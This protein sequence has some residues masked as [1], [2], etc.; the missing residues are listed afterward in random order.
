[1]PLFCCYKIPGSTLGNLLI[2]TCYGG[3]YMPSS[4]KIVNNQVIANRINEYKAKQIDEQY[5]DKDKWIKD[6]YMRDWETHALLESNIPYL[7]PIE[8]IPKFHRNGLIP[9]KN[10]IVK[11]TSP[12]LL[13]IAP[14]LWEKRAKARA[15]NNGGIPEYLTPEYK[16]A[17][18]ANFIG[19]KT[20]YNKEIAPLRV[21]QTHAKVASGNSTL[22]I[23]HKIAK[24]QDVVVDPDFARK[25]M[26]GISR[27]DF[28]VGLEEGKYSTASPF[29]HQPVDRIN[30]LQTNYSLLQGIQNVEAKNGA[31]MVY[32]L[33][34]TGPQT[35]YGDGIV[36]PNIITEF[37]ATRVNLFDKKE[38]YNEKYLLKNKTYNAV[39]GFN[40]KE[41]DYAMGLLEK[42]N[43]NSKSLTKEEKVTLER[44]ALTGYKDTKFE[45]GADGVYRFTNF[46][47][48][49]ALNG[50]I[51][52]DDV[53]RGIEFQ[54]RV[55]QENGLWAKGKEREKYMVDFMGHKMFAHEAVIAEA[56]HQVHSEDLTVLGHNIHMAD[57][58]W[59][60]YFFNN[61]KTSEGFSSYAKGLYGGSFSPKHTLD[62]LAFFHGNTPDSEAILKKLIR[63]SFGRRANGKTE[64]LSGKV[65]DELYKNFGDWK[66]K[67]G[68]TGSFTQEALM[69]IFT[70]D[71]NKSLFKQMTGF[72]DEY[73]SSLGQGT[74]HLASADAI[75]N[76]KLQAFLFNT[77]K[78]R[79]D[80]PATRSVRKLVGDGSQVFFSTQSFKSLE[81]N[82]L[83]AAV[84][85]SLTGE[86]RLSNGFTFTNTGIR[87]EGFGQIGPSRNAGYRVTGLGMLD[88]NSKI[89]QTF[90]QLNPN[91]DLGGYSY[92]QITPLSR[93]GLTAKA[94]ST[95]TLFGQHDKLMQQ[96]NSMFRYAGVYDTAT[97]TVDMSSLSKSERHALRLGMTNKKGK[98]Y[99]RDMTS[100]DI[101]EM[102]DFTFNSET[103][104]RKYREHSLKTDMGV[105]KLI[106]A[107]DNYANEQMKLNPKGHVDAYRQEYRNL[108]LDNTQLIYN[109]RL[110]GIKITEA[111]LA[112][113]NLF[114][115][116]GYQDYFTDIAEEKGDWNL[117]RE[118]V[119]KLPALESYYR[120]HRNV[121]ERTV[122]YTLSSYGK[123]YKDGITGDLKKEASMKY[124]D[125]MLALDA[126][127]DE[128]AYQIAFGNT[129]EA[130][131]VEARKILGHVNRPVLASG[132][133]GKFQID[134]TGFLGLKEN[135][136]RRNGN[137]LTL[138]LNYSG[139][140]YADKI[141][142]ITGNEKKSDQAK[143][144]ILKNF[145]DWL[146]EKGIG[147]KSDDTS[148]LSL[149]SAQIQ[150]ALRKAKGSNPM[151]GIITP[152]DSMDMFLEQGFDLISDEEIDL[153]NRTHGNGTIK[154][155]TE[156][157]DPK[158]T[159]E[160]N[161]EGFLNGVADDI[162]DILA[163]DQEAANAV[164]GDIAT[165]YRIKKDDARKLA[166]EFSKHFFGNGGMMRIDKDSG[167]IYIGSDK[168]SMVELGI[169]KERFEDGFFFNE[170][171]LTGSRHASP[172]GLFV[173]GEGEN[174]EIA[175]KSIYGAAFDNI[176]NRFSSILQG[177]A[178]EGRITDGA[179]YLFGVVRSEFTN[180]TAELKGDAHDL[181]MN[182]VFTFDDLPKYL[183]RMSKNKKFR[184]EILEEGSEFSQHF[185]KLI[186]S[187]ELDGKKFS[188]LLTD[189][190]NIID[191]Y[192]NTI[193]DN[194]EISENAADFN[195]I[196]KQLSFAYKKANKGYATIGSEN[197]TAFM[198]Q[199]SRK[200]GAEE[201]TSS[202]ATFDAEK[203]KNYIEELNREGLSVG[204]NIVTEFEY[205]ALKDGKYANKVNMN[206]IAI[207]TEDYRKAI[208]NAIEN[209]MVD[210][211]VASMLT[212]VTLTDGASAMS[213]MAAR[214][215]LD[216]RTYQQEVKL[217][218]LSTAN[219]DVARMVTKGVAPKTVI[220]P[221][222]KIEFVYSNGV[223]KHITD[224]D[225]FI[226]G[227][228]DL[229]TSF[230]IKEDSIMQLRYF[231]NNRELDAGSISD[232]LNGNSSYVERI[233][234]ASNSNEEALR[235]LMENNIEGRFLFRS[236]DMTH[237]IK[238][239]VN[240]EKTESRVI[241]Y[242]LG[243]GT[244]DESKGIRK[245]LESLGVYKEMKGR[246]LAT[247]IYDALGEED[248]SLFTMAINGYGKEGKTEEQVLSAIKDAGFKNTADFRKAI[249]KEEQ[250]PWLE[251]ENIFKNLGI[252]GEGENFDLVSN[253]TNAEAKHGEISVFE[254]AYNLISQVEGQKLN[255]QV[256][257]QKKAVEILSKEAIPG[258]K[259]ENKNGK[260][261]VFEDPSKG[262]YNLTALRKILL[263]RVGGKDEE[264]NT[265]LPKE[266]YKNWA[267]KFNETLG[268]TT[269]KENVTVQSLVN[270]DIDAFKDFRFDQRDIDNMLLQGFDE[271]IDKRVKETLM[272][273]V[274][275]LYGTD[276]ANSFYNNSVGQMSKESHTLYGNYLKSL[277]GQ[278]AF[279]RQGEA[280][281][282][283][284]YVGE[285]VV[286]NLHDKA[287]AKSETLQAILDYTNAKINKDKEARDKAKKA[288][289]LLS[290][291]QKE[292]INNLLDKG[293]SGQDI[294]STIKGLIE[295]RGATRISEGKILEHYS[296][297]MAAI[298]RE[299]N[300]GSGKYTLDNLGDQFTAISIEDVVTDSDSH[301]SPFSIFNK[302]L[303]IDFRKVGINGI[304]NSTN[305]VL[306]LPFSP[307]GATDARGDLNK[308]EIQ[309]K[310]AS[311]K[312]M[313]ESYKRDNPIGENATKRQNTIAKSIIELQDQIS[314]YTSSNSGIMKKAANIEQEGFATKANAFHFT[315]DENDKNFAKLKW[316]NGFNLSELAAQSNRNIED[317]F[318]RV[319][320][321]AIK[322]GIGKIEGNIT[323][324][325]ENAAKKELKAFF[326]RN[327]DFKTKAIS[328]SFS[329]HSEE[330][331]EK[332]YNQKIKEIFGKDNELANEFQNLLFD[333]LREN[334]TIG[335]NK[336]Y[337]I[338]YQGS[339]SANRIY[340]S[341]AVK[342]NEALVNVDYWN[343]K[344]GDFDSDALYDFMAKTR[345]TITVNG[346]TI[347]KDI[348]YGMYRALQKASK[349]NKNISVDIGKEGE[350]FFK[351][352]ENA[353]V[354]NAVM[355]G[356]ANFNN[357]E[358]NNNF[359]DAG[360]KYVSANLNGEGMSMEAALMEA[361][362]DAGIQG[363][364]YEKAIKKLS[365]ART[366][367]GEHIAQFRTYTAEDSKKYEKLFEGLREEAETSYK[368]HEERP[369]KI[370]ESLKSG[371]QKKYMAKLA[372]GKDNSG[373]LMAALEYKANQEAEQLAMS[374]SVNKGAAGILDVATND[375]LRMAVHAT[376]S[377]GTAVFNQTELEAL[378]GF[379]MS[380]EESA[381]IS[382]SGGVASPYSVKTVQDAM[383][384]IYEPIYNPT[385][386]KF[387]AAKDAA[388]VLRD[389]LMNETDVEWNQSTGQM[390]TVRT[391]GKDARRYLKLL[392]DNIAGKTDVEKLDY[393]L[394][395]VANAGHS[396]HLAWKDKGQNEVMDRKSGVKKV[397]NNGTPEHGSLKVSDAQYSMSGMEG[398]TINAIT[399]NMGFNA[400]VQ[401]VEGPKASIQE[402]RRR[403]VGDSAADYMSSLDAD[404]PASRKAASMVE[405]VANEISHSMKG[406][407]LAKTAAAVVGGLMAS[408]YASGKGT[409]PPATG[410][411]AAAQ[412]HN[413]Q[414]G[415]L[416][417]P[418]PMP[419][420]SDTNLNSRRG[421][422]KQGYVINI[423]ANSPQG[424]KAAQQ[425]I[426]DATRQQNTGDGG[427]TSINI[428]NSTSLPDRINQLQI[429]RM[430]QH[431][432]GF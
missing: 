383:K 336:R 195:E 6:D 216:T 269:R 66:S 107:I 61:E 39:I 381:L 126:L 88:S 48:K 253:L 89:Y 40:K 407:A 339:T 259:I 58:P 245:V 23:G 125:R 386:E 394:N 110:N 338:N 57:N 418:K 24:K 357:A 251:L 151:S 173:K 83:F 228:G 342:G 175:Y 203:T 113:P 8:D 201:Y 368:A 273:T 189:Q 19:N 94:S 327:L 345:A 163:P 77:M 26:Q 7:V 231:R 177:N 166:K 409:P 44:M 30:A 9:D 261:V 99:T 184:N 29:I 129:P 95:I 302:N 230:K 282:Y 325:K 360:V 271:T 157:Y 47:D 87:K 401:V 310:V 356:G 424:R 167:R 118:T 314:K 45:K 205:G 119:D 414:M 374:V 346:E 155:L 49:K 209:K 399:N 341:K 417:Q 128:K 22:Y 54:K 390:E 432:M 101:L 242:G 117:Y 32:D 67:N 169:T 226:K 266:E 179:N 377:D 211:D 142:A 320:S 391:V 56:L 307:I 343:A 74:A 331:M 416:Y 80:R 311:I 213:I 127:M 427:N 28:S 16:A 69:G 289:E 4:T 235:I 358:G 288:G 262:N 18:T 165:N 202:A 257:G 17:K 183:K 291:K 415:E 210:D 145:Q 188:E 185:L 187:D 123:T 349:S 301:R 108:L 330:N 335:I 304:T 192:I 98:R 105:L 147:E 340:F 160:E 375:M 59:M 134:L 238:L 156:N 419:K 317:E 234:N 277:T 388:N 150:K 421:G 250:A 93:N 136:E 149:V 292:G 287:K 430:V 159:W 75:G 102:S 380:I 91:L 214:T 296:A 278:Q 20:E 332:M 313:I 224:S 244:G 215:G 130:I 1:M 347:E 124:K 152:V 135:F 199:G 295:E 191:H 186:D 275:K 252:I 182:N 318:K 162:A 293:M 138:D 3:L 392:D 337:P 200:R 312:G 365:E 104:A 15:E 82:G 285:N 133:E 362:K 334:G 137:I 426:M 372:Q 322:S 306:A 181:R 281:I 324:E 12:H 144:V 229:S 223:F 112:M 84:D 397:Y 96:I 303:I 249:L 429:G 350:A 265:V 247:Y 146:H 114:N 106:D 222:G 370:W 174:A 14:E 55:G 76:A 248:V 148:D 237:Q 197:Y 290:K 71:I 411:A 68:I 73:I 121:I 352:L 316:Q 239:G 219:N 86:L 286:K 254:R 65:V 52:P 193:F 389:V 260:N 33:E 420:L 35:L 72:S 323:E 308:N 50:I 410:Q 115:L 258:L 393:T 400:P 364:F 170:N 329:I 366:Y 62:P 241:G 267:N 111:D 305:K 120:Q 43:T 208:K 64:K 164:G 206:N 36:G 398:R 297:S 194:L 131:S 27:K 41:Y 236:V 255:S 328:P 385:S 100:D 233:K 425:A 274:G 300:T 403:R 369:E 168:E 143:L 153:S 176:G 371:E 85:D 2:E 90:S 171:V 319:S 132:Y 284:D 315:G 154:F 220:T 431:S 309:S 190:Q 354:V 158:K 13:K 240:T 97:N 5:K 225:I 204:E 256:E 217:S 180:K 263:E 31:A 196:R 21:Y 404:V 172:L 232:I 408:G 122:N 378:Q 384:A 161:T 264:G 92:V 198:S 355:L 373:E 402:E 276:T 37:S 348:D 109:K 218:N 382:K 221:E 422:V 139:I 321:L 227:Q 413:Q 344:K 406:N 270:H 81:Q 70:G 243:E 272:N 63:E 367:D 34:A 103:A 294:V 351:E 46:T 298:A 396:I 79:L 326:S 353:E 395:V 60:S 116:V 359:I 212:S 51:N 412:S 246:N 379:R 283:S 11:I 10:G 361:K 78:K 423:S 25:V 428:T 140:N 376:K 53:L 279:T 333:D 141:A 363:T 280:I 38:L 207:T 268:I 405:T 299:F 42:Y 178:E 387:A